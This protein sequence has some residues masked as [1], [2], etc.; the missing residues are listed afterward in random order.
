LSFRVLG[1]ELS[2][3]CAIDGGEVGVEVITAIVVVFGVVMVL[4]FSWK[5]GMK[6]W[7]ENESVDLVVSEGK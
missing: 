4:G 1:R 3:S 2:R 7:G 6:M 5:M